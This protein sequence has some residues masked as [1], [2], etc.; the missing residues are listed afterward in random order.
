M[1]RVLTYGTFDVFHYGHLLHL[2]DCKELGDYLVVGV[3]SDEFNEQKKDKKAYYPY[4]I[5]KEIVSAIKYVD[6]TFEQSSFEQK[7]DDILKYNIDILVSSVEY[8]GRY[9]YLREYCE[10]IYLDRHT[11]C[12]ST[13]LRN[14]LS[15]EEIISRNDC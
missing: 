10:V 9:D 4:E 5:R 11:S 8:E 1:K 14:S 7:K 2:K 6:E 15:E 3:S 12:S 13:N